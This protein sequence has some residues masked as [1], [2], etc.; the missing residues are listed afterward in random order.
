MKKAAAFIC[1]IFVVSLLVSGCT[2]AGGETALEYKGYKISEAMYGYWAALYKRNIIYSYNNSKDTSDFWQSEISA[3]VTAEDYFTEIINEQIYKYCI[4]LQLF[5]EYGLKLDSSVTKAIDDDI[6]EKIEYYGSRAELN[7]ALANLNLN[8]DLLRD[9]YICEEK[10]GAVYEYLYGAYGPEAL[11]DDDYVK[12]FKDNYW[13]M[14]YIVVYTTKLVTDDNGNYKY[15]SNGSLMT[16]PLSDDEMA[17][18]LAK[19]EEALARAQSGEDFDKLIEEYSEYDTS[20]YPNGFYV[21]VNNLSIYGAEILAALPGMQIDEV[22]RVEMESAIYIIKKL[23]LPEWGKLTETELL[24]LTDLEEY[25]KSEA[26]DA[27]LSALFPEVKV[28]REVLD[29]YKLSEIK[30]LSVSNI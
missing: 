23:E 18:K 27:K 6:K 8:I 26:F 29:K 25:A 13:R 11:S 15:D 17:Q 24:Q 3:G 21:S 7:S 14:K 10:L 19:A 5:D 4:G 30:M 28:N 2:P 12:Y 22:R 9:I 1:V 20:S 16:E